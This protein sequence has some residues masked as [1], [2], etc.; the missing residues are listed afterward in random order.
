MRVAAAPLLPCCD[1]GL[2]YQTFIDWLRGTAGC[3]DS[4]NAMEFARP[5]LP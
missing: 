3:R 4:G 1:R 2:A 5:D